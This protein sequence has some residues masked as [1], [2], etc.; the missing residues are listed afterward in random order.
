MLQNDSENYPFEPYN[1]EEDEPQ[2]ASEEEIRNVDGKA[3]DAG[4]CSIFNITP[5]DFESH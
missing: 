3:F 5:P 4:F 2:W 1:W